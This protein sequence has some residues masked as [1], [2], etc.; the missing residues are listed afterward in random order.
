VRSIDGAEVFGEQL[1]V[2]LGRDHRLVAASGYVS[3]RGRAPIAAV[4]WSAAQ[5]AARGLEDFGGTPGLVRSAG[6]AP[7]GYEA[8][9]RVAGAELTDPIRVKRV[10]FHLP[11]RFEPA[12]TVEVMGEREAVAYVISA[13]DGSLLRRIGQTED[14]NF[15]YRVWAEAAGLHTPYDGPQGTGPT[16]HPTGLPDF[17]RPAFVPP[18]LV[19][20]SNGPIPTSDP[21]LD[22]AATETNGNNVDAYADLSAPMA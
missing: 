22:G 2:L 7:G 18:V 11:D 15:S 4:R 21:W 12:Y 19:S 5:A 6:A 16:P 9:A 1:N 13:V 3:P 10:L 17:Y 14:V 8:F 20:L